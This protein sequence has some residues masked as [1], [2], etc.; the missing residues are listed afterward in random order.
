MPAS[1]NATRTRLS[2][3]IVLRTAI[4]LADRGGLDAITMRALAD[5]LGVEAMSLYY[6]LSNKDAIL[7]GVVEEVFAEVE[8]EVGG[9]GVPAATDGAGWAPALRERILG[10]RRVLLR[11]PWAPWI[12]NA[13]GAPGQNAMRHVDGIVGIMRAGGMSYDLIH[14]AL[15]AIG[16]RVYGY[17]QE[18]SDDTAAPAPVELEQLATLAPNLAGML[19]EVAHDDP[20]STLG[21]CDDQTEF[22]F[23]L[24]LL[25]EGLERRRVAAGG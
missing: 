9:F 14:H 21:W 23:G 4:E 7:D 15:H 12:M 18:L 1:K 22:E 19:G 8:A 17:V 6:H 11:H 20:D 13:R 10:A 16:S 2:R 5:E 25:L 24:D 3:D